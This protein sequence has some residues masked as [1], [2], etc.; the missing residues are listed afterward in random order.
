MVHPVQALR[1]ARSGSQ[2]VCSA[3]TTHRGH[4][5]WRLVHQPSS[6]QLHQTTQL[7]ALFLEPVTSVVRQATTL[8]I[9]PRTSYRIRMLRPVPEATKMVV[10]SPP[11]RSTPRNPLLP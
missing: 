11:R 5:M 10:A 3:R 8:V 9:V 4:P 1:S 6:T 7:H 2:I